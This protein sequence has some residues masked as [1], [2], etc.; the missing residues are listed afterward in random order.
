[1]TLMKMKMSQVSEL[2]NSRPLLTI[3]G[4]Q[5][6]SRSLVLVLLR[7]RHRPGPMVIQTRM[8]VL[9]TRRLQPLKALCWYIYYSSATYPLLIFT[10]RRT[11][12][13]KV[14]VVSD[15]DNEEVPQPENEKKR[16]RPV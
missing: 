11:N 14:Q 6:L 1:M 8:P 15:D 2:N 12:N 7:R 13:K 9:P 10:Q 4:G 5:M 16:R 3:V